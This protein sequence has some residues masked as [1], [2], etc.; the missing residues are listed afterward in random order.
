MSNDTGKAAGVPAEVA[1]SVAANVRRLRQSRGWSLEALAHRAG[2][3][4]GALVAM[5]QERGNPSLSTLCRLGDA[6]GLALTELISQP[7]EP[8]VRVVDV[9]DGIGL[10][11]SP[12]CTGQLILSSDPPAPVEFWRARIEPGGRQDSEAHAAGT[13]EICHVDNGCLTLTVAGVDTRVSTGQVVTYSGDRPHSY[14]NEDDEPVTFALVVRVA[15]AA[16][17]TP[18]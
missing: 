14:R 2:I 16:E 10:W 7:A 12:G 5:E 15:D 8:A 1:R 4:K 13:R 6:F 11:T 3:S 18:E 17:P 9:S